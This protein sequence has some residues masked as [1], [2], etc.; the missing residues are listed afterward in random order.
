[1]A[2][3]TSELLDYYRSRVTSYPKA[4]PRAIRDNAEM[5]ML[6][7]WYSDPQVRPAVLYKHKAGTYGKE[8]EEIAKEDI[9]FIH[10]EEQ[11][12]NSQQVQFFI[13]FKPRVHYPLGT[14]ID[15]PDEQYKMKRWLIVKKDDDAQFNRYSILPCNYTVKWIYKNHIYE[16]LTVIRSVNSYSS[17]VKERDV[18][19]TTDNRCK[20]IMPT[21]EV[22]QA[23]F[24]DVRL[25]VSSDRP[26]PF[27]W[28]TTKIEELTPEGVSQ[29]TIS[30]DV[31]NIETDKAEDGTIIADINTQVILPD[32]DEEHTDIHS[33]ITSYRVTKDVVQEFKDRVALIGKTIRFIGKFYDAEGNELPYN[34]TSLVPKWTINGLSSLD[35][36]GNE[37]FDYSN[38]TVDKDYV[39]TF[40]VNKDYY[41][42]GT[43][44]SVT[45]SNQRGM[46][47]STMELEIET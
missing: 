14:Y 8:Y 25:I 9:K 31:F 37:V 35:S 18:I 20:M 30:Q 41:L 43:R 10:K 1:M 27:V 22:S 2:I 29:F 12:F 15:I 26:I 38:Y 6:N 39:L 32:K 36:E 42:G 44:F 21:D 5:I 4:M 23:L 13:Q 33:V 3:S 28:K 46:Y 24:Y 16:C 11:P 45:F 19:Y 17:G 47:S 7:S 34:D 40:K